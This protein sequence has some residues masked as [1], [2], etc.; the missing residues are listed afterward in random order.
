MTTLNALLDRAAQEGGERPAF[1]MGERAVSFRAVRHEVLSTAEGLRRSGVLRGDRVAIVHRNAPEFVV[2]YFALNRLGAVAVPINFMVQKADELAYMLNDCGACG[3]VTQ[4]EFLPGLIAAAGRCPAL[5]ALWTTDLRAGG[6]HPAPVRDFAKLKETPP[7]DFPRDPAVESDTAAI[8]YTS[9]TTGHPKGVMLT[10]R[11]LV[12]NC[13]SS[14]LRMRLSRRDVTLCILPMF[15]SFAWTAIVLTS[16]RLTMKCVVSAAVAPAK[17]WLKAMGRHGVTLFAA[18]PQVYAALSRE[19][20]N[21]KTRLFLRHWAFRKVTLAVSG[22]APLPVPIAEAFASAVGPA[23]LEGWGLTE[24]SPVAA[25]NPPGAVRLGTV[26]TAIDGVRLKIIDDAEAGLPAGAEGEVCVQGENVMKGYWNKPA[27]TRE[28]FTA[29]GWLKTGDI[30]ALD[31]DGYLTIRDRKKDMIIIKGLKVFSAQVEAV[32]G[33]HPAV[34]E[35]AVV[36]L[37]DE[38]GDETIK[39]FVVLKKGACAGKPELLKFFRDRL[40]A[41]K[42]PRDLE[43]VESLPKNALQ[44]ILKRELRE[45][46]LA[47]RKT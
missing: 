32:I 39:A 33:E 20:K 36:G 4:T 45:R 17:P 9:G 47:R 13:E 1:V 41:Y 38:L 19:A 35:S 34:E 8:L 15:H 24:T 11:N 6:E 21:L 31:A 7:E 18:V 29:D 40:D 28:T 3:V 43:I 42:R 27:E 30:G 46:D 25:V 5:K 12:T 23:V 44:K 37:P 26:G 14:L 22:A 2:A 16:L 10:H